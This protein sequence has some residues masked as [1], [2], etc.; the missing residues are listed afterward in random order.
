MLGAANV[1]GASLVGTLGEN[2]M[3]VF[4]KPPFSITI[5]LLCPIYRDAIF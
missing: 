2:L 1:R 4:E 5:F 3:R